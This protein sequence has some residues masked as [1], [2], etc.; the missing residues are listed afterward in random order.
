MKIDSVD[1]TEI[2]WVDVTMSGWIDAPWIESFERKIH[3]AEGR[4]LRI[5][6][7]S[8]GGVLADAFDL[9]GKLQQFRPIMTIAYGRCESA[10]TIIFLAGH[11]RVINEGA[12]FMVHNPRL[13]E[14]TDHSAED[15][16]SG[17]RAREHMTNCYTTRTGLSRETVVALMEKETFLDAEEAKRLG[18]ATHI[19][20]SKP[21]DTNS[22]AVNMPPE[23]KIPPGGDSATLH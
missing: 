3:L 15:R 13:I 9:F 14:G 7:D 1:V 16:A 22:I 17:E 11:V 23:E 19:A 2:D 6:I 12:R 21:R 20:R 5:W 4:P 8:P 10:A 18:F